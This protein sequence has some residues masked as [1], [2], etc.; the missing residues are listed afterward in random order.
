MSLLLTF[1]DLDKLYESS[2]EQEAQKLIAQ[3]RSTI[4]GKN[5]GLTGRKR[6]IDELRS[7]L[8]KCQEKDKIL[9]KPVSYKP[10]DTSKKC[11]SCKSYL[12]LEGRCT[13]CDPDFGFEGVD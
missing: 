8:R 1:M 10:E 12:S 2:E 4:S 7:I 3:I 13:K 6:S 5:Y 9:S 11:P